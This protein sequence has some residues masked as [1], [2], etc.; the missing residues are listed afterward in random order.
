MSWTPNLKNQLYITVTSYPICAIV[1]MVGLIHGHSD[2][3]LYV[4]RMRAGNRS[5]RKVAIIFCSRATQPGKWALIDAH[6][7]HYPTIHCHP[8]FSAPQVTSD[9][10]QC[11]TWLSFVQITTL[12]FGWLCTILT[13]FCV[14]TVP[15]YTP[16]V[17]PFLLP[18]IQKEIQQTFRMWIRLLSIS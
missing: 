14:S 5:G 16:L 7:I 9:F 17:C 2:S 13:V 3:L 6:C 15:T 18:A 8:A 10:E 1:S 4:R 12:E 11:C